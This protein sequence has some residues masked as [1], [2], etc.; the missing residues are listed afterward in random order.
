MN[1]EEIEKTELWQLY[2]K[3]VNYN[4][5]MNM[6]SDTDTNF[7]FYNGDQ[8]QGLKSGGIEPVSYN[9]LKPIV[10]HQVG[11]INQNLWGINYSSDN[12]DNEDMIKLGK[13][14]CSLLN[15]RASRVFEKDN[16]DYKLRKVSK[17]SAINDEGLIYVDYNEETDDPVNEIVNKV[18]VCYGN[19]NSSDIQSQPY[20]IIKT[21]KPVSYVQ[22][23]ARSKGVDEF[24]VLNIRGDNDTIEESG[25][26]AKYEV[27]DMC[28]IITKM[29]KK[30]GTVHFSKA[31]KFVDIQKDIDTGLTLYP[32]VHMVWEEV[33]GYSRGIGLVKYLRPNQIEINKTL[34]RRTLTVKQTAY[35]Q[36]V[37]LIDAIQ[38]P[39]AIGEVGSTI[40]VQGMQI[41]DVRKAFSYTNPAQMS[42]DATNLQ[43]ELIQ[44]TRDL[45][46]SSELA[47]G[48]VNPEDASGRAI[49]AV[50]QASNMPLGE[51]TLAL[52]TMIEDLARIY[53]DMWKTYA[54]QGLRV[55]DTDDNDEQVINQITVEML[56][57]LQATV[58]V[59]VTPKSPYDKFA[60]EQSIENLF[61]SEKISFEEYVKLLPEDSVMPKQQLQIIVE[62]RQQAQQEIAQMQAQAN[63]LMSQS[64][65][66]MQNEE[67]IANIEAMGNQMA[68]A[69]AM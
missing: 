59:D 17:Q 61:M 6:Y 49:L 56:Q 45:N 15:K 19:E 28:T 39:S 20:I 40:K 68:E 12:F 52:K 34:M 51:Q 24:S 11:T 67:E 8:W 47:T 62:D 2:E 23:L 41:D 35:Q 22:E 46:N 69:T 10:K 30:N 42:P 43:T 7:R 13:K 9:V 32:L 53:L 27:D 65:Q 16:M 18:D 66:I 48:N 33:E 26:H 50:Q 1:L 14:V 57:E 29:Y 4:R 3:G 5:M 25:E 44:T 54:E 64:N 37:V 55:V 31:T 58:R 63:Q 36:R 21:R 60:V 38:N